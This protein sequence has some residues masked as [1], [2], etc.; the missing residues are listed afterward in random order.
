MSYSTQ[1]INPD[2][3]SRQSGARI[4]DKHSN[5]QIIRPIKK[6]LLVEEDCIQRRIFVLSSP[7]ISKFRYQLGSFQNQIFSSDKY[8]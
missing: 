1:K 4:T 6:S 5:Q 7:T 8:F 2:N 3:F